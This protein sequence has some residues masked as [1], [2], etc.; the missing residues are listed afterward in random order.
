MKSLSAILL[1]VSLSAIA[2]AT[3]FIY[4]QMKANT[5]ELTSQPASTRYSTYTYKTV[6]GQDLKMNVY[7]PTTGHKPFPATLAI[8]GGGWSTGSRGDMDEIA[9]AM[10]QR[11]WVV[12]SIDYRLSPQHQWPTQLEDARAAVRYLRAHADELEIDPKRLAS[13]GVSAGGHLSL[14]LGAIGPDQVAAVGSIS[15]IHN[16]RLPLTKEGEDYGIVPK[17]L[18]A[19][20]E[21][22]LHA[23]SPYDFLDARSAP[24]FF[25]QGDQDPLV[26]ANQ[27]TE[28]VAKL[29]KLKVPTE[30]ILVPKMGHGL[31]PRSPL[32]AQALAKMSD[33]LLAQFK[34]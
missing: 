13:I 23:G 8:H 15:G 18:G 28:A 22:R 19:L 7:T 11:G 17:L 33:W 4:G 1:V 21:D 2:T 32:Q 24:S 20:T 10:A 16:L 6:A 12:A 31:E 9:T 27:S 26:P 3:Y 25:I 5:D 29:K 34:R 30:Y 14:F